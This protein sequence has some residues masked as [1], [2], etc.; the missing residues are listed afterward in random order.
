MLFLFAATSVCSEC[1]TAG[2]HVEFGGTE[3]DLAEAYYDSAKDSGS[4]YIVFTGSFLPR[5]TGTHTFTVTCTTYFISALMPAKAH[6]EWD[7]LPVKYG[8]GTWTWTADLTQDFRYSYKC[9]TDD[10][11]YYATLQLDVTIPGGA[12]FTVNT[13]YSDVCTAIGCRNL[14]YTRDNDCLPPSG[15]T[16]VPTVRGIPAVPPKG[17]LAPVWIGVVVVAGVGVVIAIVVIVRRRR[18][19]HTGAIADPLLRT[20]SGGVPLVELE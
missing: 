10:N 5:H 1:D 9:T 2:T 7:E 6:L 19:V 18:V 20:E 12:Q 3:R 17:S 13:D 16:A 4:H 11:F 15:R 14:S 8:T